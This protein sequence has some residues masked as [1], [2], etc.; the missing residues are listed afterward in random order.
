MIKVA[1]GMMYELQDKASQFFLWIVWKL[2]VWIHTIIFK[3]YKVRL[4]CAIDRDDGSKFYYWQT[5]WKWIP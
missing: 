2:P 3:K 4:V 5:H 1:I